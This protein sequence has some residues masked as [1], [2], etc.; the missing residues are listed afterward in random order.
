[1]KLDWRLVLVLVLSLG[2]MVS[3]DSTEEED[4]TPAFEVL[5][6]YMVA[7]D[8]D[9]TSV[10]ADWI[11]TASAINE[12]GVD[13]YFILDIRAEGDYTTG[14]IAGAVNSAY[15]D[16]LTTV[17]AENTG[18]LPIIVVCY[19]GQTAAH[20]VVALRLNVSMVLFLK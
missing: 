2:L 14:H 7:N 19:T 3:C 4:A 8:Y 10:V 6:D 18:D 17:E 5:T 1:M 11:T 13:N 15:A 16:I 20:A 9:A 12:A